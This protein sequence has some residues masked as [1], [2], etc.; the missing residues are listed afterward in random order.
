[1]ISLTSFALHSRTFKYEK[2]TVP[3]IHPIVKSSFWVLT[4]LVT[5]KFILFSIRNVCFGFLLENIH[6]VLCIVQLNQYLFSYEWNM[7]FCFG[8]P[9]T[10]QEQAPC[11]YW[12]H[13]LLVAIVWWVAIALPDCYCK[14][15]SWLRFVRLCIMEE[16][17]TT[18]GLLCPAL[19]SVQKHSVKEEDDQ[20][21]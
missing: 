20:W 12:W 17:N 18:V 4:K 6:D 5:W 13:F 9:G 15:R 2:R 21:I 3:S 10:H 16:N 11:P 1:M 7:Q 8:V 19:S 14:Q